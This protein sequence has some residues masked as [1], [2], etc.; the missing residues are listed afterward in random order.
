MHEGLVERVRQLVD[1]QAPRD[2]E[3][4][5]IELDLLIARFGRTEIAAAL[6][7]VAPV[8]IAG[9]VRHGR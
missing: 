7:I 5:A 6:A 3:V 4:A 2:P 1:E 9:L 8:E